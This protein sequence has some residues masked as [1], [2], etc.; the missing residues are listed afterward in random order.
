MDSCY[1]LVTNES[2]WEEALA[3]CREDGAE[4]VSVHS[5]AENA[6]ILIVT[7]ETSRTLWLG[8][9]KNEVSVTARLYH[10]MLY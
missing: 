10:A 6:A 1:K 9:H 2:T 4:L 7:S 8:L 5:E 3:T